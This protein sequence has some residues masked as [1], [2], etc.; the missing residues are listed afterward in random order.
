MEQSNDLKKILSTDN[1]N[2]L[3]DSPKK[4]K[5]QYNSLDSMADLLTMV[6]NECSNIENKS[7]SKIDK[8]NKAGILNKFI[9]EYIIINELSE[10]LAKQLKSLLIK[11]FNSNLLNKQSDVKYN[12]KTQKIEKIIILNLNEDTNKYEIVIKGNKV[13][14][15]PKTKSMTNIDRVLN[16][17]KKK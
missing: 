13:K 7:W 1:I 8:V 2:E 15:T 14:V 11:S 16:R 3:D 4:N 6:D 10:D 9:D 12:I 5:K 17:S